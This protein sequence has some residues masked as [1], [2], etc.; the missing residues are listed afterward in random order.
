MKEST[1]QCVE[2]IWPYVPHGF[3]LLPLQQL[4]HPHLPQ[5]GLQDWTYC[6]MTICQLQI[7]LKAVQVLTSKDLLWLTAQPPTCWKQTPCLK[8]HRPWAWLPPHALQF[9]QELAIECQIEPWLVGDPQSHSNMQSLHQDQTNFSPASPCFITAGIQGCIYSHTYFN[10]SYVVSCL[11]WDSV[12][13]LN[14]GDGLW[15][16]EQTCETHSKGSNTVT[17]ALINVRREHLRYYI[18]HK[19]WQHHAWPLLK[20]SI[21]KYIRWE[22]ESSK[23]VV[24]NWI[25]NSH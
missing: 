18:P 17:G 22:S 3:P 7:N 6:T 2:F 12:T 15:G 14:C 11:F 1:L 25:N 16:V 8:E 21:Q 13:K 9:P 10:T 19:W 5:A 24:K 4:H 23:P 20:P